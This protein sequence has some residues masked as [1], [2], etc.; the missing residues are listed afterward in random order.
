MAEPRWVDWRIAPL[1]EAHDAAEFSCGKPSLDTFIRRYALR[2]QRNDIGRT[3]VGVQP[4]SSRV[5]GYYTITSGKVVHENLPDEERRMLPRYPVP[6]VLIGRLAVDR[7]AQGHGLGATLLLDA[8][9]VAQEASKLMGV[10]GV[11]V[12]ALDED[13]RSFYLKYGF[14]SL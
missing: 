10:W 1:S 4:R 8:L 12:D 3:F 7:Q 11:E 13:A 9:H 14:R 2:N 5:Q 6:V